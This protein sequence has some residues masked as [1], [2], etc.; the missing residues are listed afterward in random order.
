MPESSAKSASQATTN[1][2]APMV[3]SSRMIWIYTGYAAAAL[4]LLGA[5]AYHF[6]SYVMR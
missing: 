5:L 4:A 3:E 6:S 1:N 2:N